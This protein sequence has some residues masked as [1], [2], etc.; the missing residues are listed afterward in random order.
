MERPTRA[1]LE[2]Q[3]VSAVYRALEEPAGR[4]HSFTFSPDPAAPPE[5]P[6]RLPFEPPWA[7]I[8]AWNPYSVPEPP[9]A[10]QD[11]QRR[12]VAAIDSLGFRHH[13]A[14]G[15]SPDDPPTWREDSLL[16]EELEMQPALQLLKVFRQHAAVYCAGGKA[17]LLYADP[18]LW[19][20][21][22]LRI[23]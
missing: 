22:P 10:N 8:T 19:K 2:A 7:I 4:W 5:D 16:V 13:P 15:R 1:Q 12:L 14:E 20:V 3:Y 18:E 6:A 11:A 21:Y 9:E 17:G 23:L